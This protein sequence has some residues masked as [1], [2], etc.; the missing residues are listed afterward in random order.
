[1]R[2]FAK[3][4]DHVPGVGQHVDGVD[5]RIVAVAAPGD[6]IEGEVLAQ[7]LLLA[8]GRRT[9]AEAAV[10]EDDSLGTRTPALYGIFHRVAPQMAL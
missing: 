2:A 6:D 10:D 3:D 7:G 1:V 4:L 8:E 9:V 5:R